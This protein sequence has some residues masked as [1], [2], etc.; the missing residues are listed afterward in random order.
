ME[1]DRR[2]GNINNK[3]EKKSARRGVSLHAD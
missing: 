2:T 3:N 1:E